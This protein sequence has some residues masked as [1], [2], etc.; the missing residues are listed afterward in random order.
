MSNILQYK[1][2]YTFQIYQLLEEEKKAPYL[3]ELLR[4]DNHNVTVALTTVETI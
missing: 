4:P 2:T 1:L 3:R